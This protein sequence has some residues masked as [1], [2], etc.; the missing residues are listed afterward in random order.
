MGIKFYKCSHCGNIITFIENKGVPII[1][2]GE[3]MNEL[4]ANTTDGAAEKHVPV[5]S[6]EGTTVNVSIGSVDH[7]MLE[8]HY[9]QW[10]VLE[11]KQGSQI[12][13]L[14]PGADPKVSFSISEEDEVTAVYEYCNLHG[15]WKA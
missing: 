11:T 1:C 8:E 14:S 3:K 6:I 5:Y 7:P 2:C 12:K 13:Y 9:I 4:T 15:L 10:I